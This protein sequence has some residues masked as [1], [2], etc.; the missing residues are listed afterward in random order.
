M[1]NNIIKRTICGLLTAVT[2]VT[3]LAFNPADVRACDLCKEGGWGENIKILSVKRTGL[4][5]AK[6]TVT[7]PDHTNIKVISK[8]SQATDP[9]QDY[10]FEDRKSVV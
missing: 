7:I 5:T 8:L 10:V 6:V 9:N 2:L 1:K 4:T 3:G